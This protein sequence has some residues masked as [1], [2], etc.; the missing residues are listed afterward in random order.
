LI[1]VLN[2]IPT[3]AGQERAIAEI[4]RLL[5][6]GGIVF[7]SDYPLQEDERNR[8]RYHDFEKEFGIYGAFRTGAAVF[9][10][11][12]MTKIGQ[13]LSNFDILWKANVKVLTMN[14]NPADV[15]QIIARKKALKLK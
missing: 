5:R 3:D 6:D 15:F 13:L 1:A 11:H 12:D 14:G 8:K 4:S 10:H 9:R 7:I 2:C